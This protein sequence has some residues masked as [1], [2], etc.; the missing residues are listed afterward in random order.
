LRGALGR[1]EDDAGGV[2]PGRLAAVAGLGHR[3]DVGLGG[4]EGHVHVGELALH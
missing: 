2:L 4:V 3:I 1:V